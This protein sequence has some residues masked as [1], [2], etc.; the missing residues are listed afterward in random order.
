MVSFFEYFKRVFITDKI[1]SFFL[2]AVI[3]FQ[4][5]KITAPITTSGYLAVER[6]C[7]FTYLK[8]KEYMYLNIRRT[9]FMSVKFLFLLCFYMFS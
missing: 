7:C 3:P 2:V 4:H 5:E 9:F 8:K 1:F 6:S